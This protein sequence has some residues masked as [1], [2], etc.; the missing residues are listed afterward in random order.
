[1]LR[2]LLAC[3]RCG[4]DLSD[5]AG[6]LVCSRCD[7][8][9]PVVNGVP[10]FTGEPP[11]AASFGLQWNRYRLEQLDSHNGSSLSE[12][13][14]FAE[15]DWSRDWL[16]GKLVLD[17]GCG[18]GRFAEIAAKYGARV[19]AVDVSNAVHAARATLERYPQ[20]AVVQASITAL[21]FREGTF[22]GVYCFGVAQHTPDPQRTIAALPPM[23]RP[24]GRLAI[25]VYERKPQTRFYSKY[26]LRPLTRRLPP[27]M[28][29]GLIRLS[30]PVL[31]PLT[32]VLFRL[33][34]VGKIFRFLIPVANC[35]GEMPLGFRQRYRWARLDTFDML[36]PGYDQ[37]LREDE[38]RSALPEYV[39]AVRR[40]P[41]AGLNVVAEAGRESGGRTSR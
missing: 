34:K 37:P 11:Y 1:M 24:G 32:E 22:D 5:D 13:R 12:T 28:T 27:R 8:R 16:E 38:L 7:R 25:T 30:M 41:N 33:P 15:T 17:A 39:T 21:P 36:S 23:L 10:S 26:L 29:S 18:A 31:F 20:A 3:P 4:G 9:Y 35:P 40:Q 6:D 14:F 19:V 2:E